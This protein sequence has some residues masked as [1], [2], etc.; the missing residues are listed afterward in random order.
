M[1]ISA[2]SVIKQIAQKYQIQPEYLW[3]QFPQY[4][5][6]R[7]IKNHKWFAILM[8]I[9]AEKIGLT[10]SE[11]LWVLNVK[12]APEMIGALRMIKGIYPAYHMNKTHWV[13]LNL[14]EIDEKLLWQ[15]VAESFS[16][17]ENK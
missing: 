10:S 14:T 6:F 3:K 12:A 15:L 4:A 13:S 8:N 9:N 2:D 16:L 17:I 11:I 5:V 1:T 7:H